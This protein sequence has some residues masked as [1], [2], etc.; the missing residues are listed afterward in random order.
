MEAAPVAAAQQPPQAQKRPREES[1][2]SPQEGSNDSV[3]ATFSNE[4]SLTTPVVGAELVVDVDQSET[5]AQASAVDSPRSRSRG[6]PAV[7]PGPISPVAAS[8]SGTEGASSCQAAAV[9][10]TLGSSSSAFADA[11]RFKQPTLAAYGMVSDTIAL[12]KEISD[13]DSHI[14]EL[15]REVEGLRA[16]VGRRD[17]QIHFMDGQCRQ[18]QKKLEHFQSVMRQEMLS[19]AQ[20]DRSEARRVLYQK[21]FELGQTA[22]WHS[23]GQTV[24][25]EGDRVRTL[26]LTLASLTQKREEAEALKKAAQSSVKHLARQERERED[27]SAGADLQDALMAAQMEYQLRTSEHAALTNSIADVKLKQAEVEHEKKAFVK[28]MRRVNDEDTSEFLA[29][30]TIGEGDRYVLMHLLGKGGFSEVWKAFD[31]V[32]GRYVACK[33]HHIQR[34]W[35]TQTRTHYLRHAQRELD[36]MR[37]LDHPH[38]THLYDVFPRGDNMFISVMEY[39]NGMDL[40]TYL[41][42]YRTFKEADARLIF[43]QVVD[44][45]R[46]LASLESPIIHYDLKPANILLHRDDPTILDIKI[47]DFGLSKIIGATREGPSDNPS[48]ELTSQGTGT[49]WYLPPE[50]FET[51]STPRISNK[52]DIWSAGVI[53]YQMLFGRRPFAEGESQRRIWQEKLIIQSAR[54]LHFPD[55]PKVS[56]E[57]KDVIRACL[58]FNEHERCDVFQLSQDPYLFRTSRRSTHKAKSAALPGGGNSCSPLMPPVADATPAS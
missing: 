30:P 45:L 41:K 32:E 39:S 1:D 53:F 20:K 56:E 26:F 22:T 12:K 58:A 47:T 16:E 28:E 25:M 17:D 35:P 29:I 48:I 50:C 55:A 4:H 44:V 31:L 7:G 8:R 9:V 14:E 11:R 33:I 2:A 15:N 38:L 49:Y 42:R 52:V 57:A 19:A 40:D 21:H 18:Y 27:S 5:N 34:E 24:W 43:L 37:A 36:I 54:T 13:R 6:L 51:A 23:N 10:A 3:P 46:Y